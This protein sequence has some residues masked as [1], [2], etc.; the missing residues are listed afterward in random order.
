M[1]VA[2]HQLNELRDFVILCRH[3][4][5]NLLAMKCQYHFSIGEICETGV[6]MSR[7]SGGMNENNLRYKRL[8]TGNQRSR[9]SHDL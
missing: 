6:L 1:S 7:S 4:Y 2:P 5:F 9:T 8:G 3:F